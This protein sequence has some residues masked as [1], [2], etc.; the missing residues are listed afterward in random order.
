MW[1]PDPFHNELVS[2]MDELMMSFEDEIDK[3]MAVSVF[4]TQHST[5]IVDTGK[6]G[7]SKLEVKVQLKCVM[8]QFVTKTIIKINHL[9]SKGTAALCS[10][11]CQSQ[12]EVKSLKVK[13][14][15]MTDGKEIPEK[16]LGRTPQ[17]LEE[18]EWTGLPYSPEFAEDLEVEVPTPIDEADKTTNCKETT[19]RDKTIEMKQCF[20]SL[21]K[22]P[23]SLTKSNKQGPNTAKQEASRPTDREA[24]SRPTDIQTLSTDAQSLSV[25]S[26]L[27]TIPRKEKKR[28]EAPMVAQSDGSKENADDDQWEEENANAGQTSSD[29][30]LHNRKPR[31]NRKQ[32]KTTNTRKEYLCP[33]CG[34]VF[35]K[36]CNFK[37]H[38]RTHTGERPY[39]CELCGKCFPTAW[40]LRNHQLVVHRR[41]KPLECPTCGKYFA[42]KSYLDK[43]ASVHSTEKPFRC[44][45]CQKCFKSKNGLKEHTIL[46]NS[47]SN[48]YACDKCPKT[49]VKLKYLK[50]HQQTHSGGGAHRCKLC[51]K[52]FKS[53]SELKQH[54]ASVHRGEKPFQCPTCGKCFGKK[55][56]LKIHASVHSEERAFQCS[57][58]RMCF[59]TKYTLS[60]HK[61]TH[62]D[63]KPYACGKCP[64]TFIRS[65]YL[66]MHQAS[67]LTS[68]PL[69][70][71]YC[72]KGFK[73][74]RERK[75]HERT[76]TEEP[77]YT[78]DECGKGFYKHESLKVHVALHTGEK[79]FACDYCG[80]TFALA[81]YLKTH[82]AKFHSVTELHTCGK[83]GKKYKDIIHF[84]SHMVQ[85]C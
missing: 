10:K 44:L 29:E 12:S 16:T 13:L 64:M 6:T 45:V 56:N 38:Q 49:F 22:L 32:N 65:R 85:G 58:C 36:L 83:C 67:H 82:V 21:A 4:S 31:P 40:K 25:D 75:R 46:H 15:E 53:P 34:K 35:K 14:L 48:S 73:G 11:I 3:C 80:K 57:Q 81:S 52:G 37:Q 69:A 51:G 23:S 61:K 17:T 26:V 30:S 33:D 43:H 28:T 66:K 7:E 72:G 60:D 79:P 50:N 8:K 5:G 71:S 2:I 54:Q 62:T 55:E 70:C 68:K 41:E 77:P 78:C 20:I 76:H 42:T 19:I 39:C 27:S 74:E 84:R 59:K 9:I 1:Q 47:N 63:S 18:Q 24:K